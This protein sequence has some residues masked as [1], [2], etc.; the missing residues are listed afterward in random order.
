MTE[1]KKWHVLVVEDDKKLLQLYEHQVKVLHD[2]VVELC[3]DAVQAIYKFHASQNKYDLIITDQNMPCFG[4][5][6]IKQIRHERPE[7]KIAI[8]TG[9][10]NLNL[11]SEFR[12][13]QIFQ[14]PANVAD[15]I[16][17]LKKAS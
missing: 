14:K 6:L 9:V 15:V 5:D 16:E 10:R 11:D 7:Q 1:L 8:L 4:S 17:K 3:S 2:T 13:V 12:D